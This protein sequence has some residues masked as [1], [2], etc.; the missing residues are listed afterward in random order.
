M[1]VSTFL[2]IFFLSFLFVAFPL[3]GTELEKV[4]IGRIAYSAPDQILINHHPLILYLSSQIGIP[5]EILLYRSYETIYQNLIRGKLE[6]AWVGTAFYAELEDPQSPP[7][8]SPLWYGNE[9]YRGQIL[10]HADSKYRKIE[11]L[12]GAKMAFVGKSSSSGY[13]FPRLLLKK[14]GIELNSF[15]EFAFLEKH[16]AVVYAVLTKQFD[17]GAT[18][19]GILDLKRFQDHKTRFRVLDTTVDIPNEPILASLRLTEDLSTA[20]STAFINA[21]DAGVLEMLKNLKGFRRVSK[22]TYQTV[23]EIIRNAK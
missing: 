9:A 13:F 22:S 23:R 4:R 12:S 17:A 19:E 2:R 15:D 3:D 14:N 20:L 5:V 8:V 7:I 1:N 18:Y 21:K 6:L 11:D 16:D 10:V